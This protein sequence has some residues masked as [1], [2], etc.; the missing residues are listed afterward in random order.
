MWAG[1][2]AHN[3]LLNTGRVSD[4]GS[5]EIEH[6]ISGIYDVA[7]GAG[8]AVVFPAWMKY[9]YKHD[10]SRFKQFAMRIWDVENKIASP[11][12]TALEGIYK[13]EAFM[14][15]IGLPTHLIEMNI[16]S[17]RFEEMASKATLNDK[18]TIGHFVPMYQRDVYNI[19]K[20][21]L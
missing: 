14:K 20:F 8:L 6:E 18:R 10:V 9:M 5:H 3:N 21:A 1:T 16:G 4:W 13:F 7:D 12:Q 19:F 11:E 15:S 17:D 2:I